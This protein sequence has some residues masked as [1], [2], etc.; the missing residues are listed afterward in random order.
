MIVL[1]EVFPVIEMNLEA[2]F[3]SLPGSFRPDPHAMYKVNNVEDLGEHVD[4][5]HWC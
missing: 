3:S 1:E 2:Q 4:L 5:V